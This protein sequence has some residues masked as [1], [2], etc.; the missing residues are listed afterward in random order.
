MIERLDALEERLLRVEEQMMPSP[1]A[2]A[3][4]AALGERLEAAKVVD[5]PVHGGYP[6][7]APDPCVV[8][9]EPRTGEVANRSVRHPDGS[10]S[11][12]TWSPLLGTWVELYREPGR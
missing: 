6:D 10:T 12:E 7:G 9:V 3:K 5:R 4:L 1:G 8:A 2:G 11:V